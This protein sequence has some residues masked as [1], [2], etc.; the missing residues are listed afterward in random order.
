MLLRRY[1]KVVGGR[2]QENLPPLESWYSFMTRELE[3][4]GLYRDASYMKD[5]K[6]YKFGSEWLTNKIPSD[7]ISI[8]E[9]WE[10]KLPESMT[11]IQEYCQKFEITV[12][13]KADSTE[14]ADI[15]DVKV[16]VGENFEWFSYT[17]GYAHN[18]VVDKEAFASAILSD[19]K[20]GSSGIE[21]ALDVLTDMGF[22]NPRE[23]YLTAKACVSSYQKLVN[24]GIWDQELAE[25]L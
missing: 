1:V 6:A 13:R 2:V 17:L 16:S 11:P 3:I 5:G 24:L 9:G 22:T 7:I 8:I 10:E 19:A 21:W 4:L 23:T 25:G 20:V 12:I 14:H 15:F 18:A